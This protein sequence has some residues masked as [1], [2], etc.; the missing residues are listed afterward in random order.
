M[1]VCN[2]LLVDD[3]IEFVTSLAERLRLRGFSA[4]TASSGQA[5][6]DILGRE[7]FHVVVLDVKMPGMDGLETLKT[8]KSRHPPTEVILLT[9]HACL[10]AAVN[11]I[12]ADAF[13]YLV[14]PAD[15]DELSFKIQDAF[16]KS[17]LNPKN[18]PVCYTQITNH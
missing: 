13:D 9:G 5:A 17:C 1:T 18:E 11:G 15:L 2:V 16:E 8:I 6:L 10:D 4:T 3:E 12:Q 7:F 14:K